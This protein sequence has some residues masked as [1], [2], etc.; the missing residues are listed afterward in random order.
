MKTCITAF[1]SSWAFHYVSTGEKKVFSL[2]IIKNGDQFTLLE[3]K[4]RDEKSWL[5]KVMYSGIQ[6]LVSA[7]HGFKTSLS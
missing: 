6:N 5:A 4:S 7:F 1:C 3:I 2:E